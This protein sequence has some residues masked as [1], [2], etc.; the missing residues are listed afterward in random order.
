MARHQSGL[1]AASVCWLR[2]RKL[3][4]GGVTYAVPYYQELSIT[5]WSG[6]H[7]QAPAAL[8]VGLI[9]HR[10]HEMLPMYLRLLR[11]ACPQRLTL[12]NSFPLPTQTD[13]AL[14]DATTDT[15]F[16][17]RLTLGRLAPR[18]RPPR[19]AHHDDTALDTRSSK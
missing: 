10:T 4:S 9:S 5:P 8:D 16:P 6:P 11:C 1:V 15:V 3:S 7:L 14:D 19:V 12:I 17:Y 13:L 2:V 18:K